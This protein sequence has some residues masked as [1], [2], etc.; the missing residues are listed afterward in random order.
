MT[1]STSKGE[2]KAQQIAY[3]NIIKFMQEQE[4]QHSEDEATRGEGN[5][6]PEKISVAEARRL[7][8]VRKISA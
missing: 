2:T 1:I 3:W 7:K 8:I 5:R 6:L 4:R